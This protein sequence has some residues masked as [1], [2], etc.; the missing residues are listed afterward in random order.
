[1]ADSLDLEKELAIQIMGKTLVGV[2]QEIQIDLNA[3]NR[4]IESSLEYCRNYKS[5]NTNI[6]YN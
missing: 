5:K 6:S 1:M 2:L 4:E 3:M